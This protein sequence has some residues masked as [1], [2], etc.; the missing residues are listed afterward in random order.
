MGDTT[1]LAEFSTIHANLS[2]KQ[3]LVIHAEAPINFLGTAQRKL[4]RYF[5]PV[6]DTIP[7]KQKVGNP[8][9][10]SNPNTWHTLLESKITSP[11]EMTGKPSFSAVLK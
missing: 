7:K 2:S 8:Q 1:I 9:G 5:D 11:I 4:T 6:T 3:C 10:T